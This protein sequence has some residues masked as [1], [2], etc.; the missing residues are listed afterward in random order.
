MCRRLCF[1]ARVA[2]A[3]A[4]SGLLPAQRKARG[5]PAVAGELPACDPDKDEPIRSSLQ[6]FRTPPPRV[7]CDHFEFLGSFC[8]A[9]PAGLAP[10][11]ENLLDAVVVLRPLAGAQ[12]S[13]SRPYTRDSRAA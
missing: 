8:G 5:S 3:H 7:H 4:Q 10:V 13:Q 6:A 9:R 2:R 12:A 1:D 11:A